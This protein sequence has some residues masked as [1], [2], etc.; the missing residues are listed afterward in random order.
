MGDHAAVLDDAHWLPHR[1]DPARGTVEFIR[2]ARERL[3]APAFL[4][5]A[6]AASPQDICAIP[7]AEVAAHHPPQAPQHFIFHTAFCRSTLLVRA[8]EQPGLCAGLSE[9]GVIASLV[10]AGP[11][12]Q[13]AIAPVARLLARP[14]GAGENGAE[15]VF[16][17]P[18]NHANMIAGALLEARPEARAALMTN[19]LPSFLRAVVRKGMLG[20]RWARTLYLEMMGYAGMDLGMDGREQFAMTDLQAGALAWFLNQRFLIALEQRFGA[21]VRVLDGDAFGADPAGTLAAV[22]RFTGVP[23][24]TG[25]PGRTS[26]RVTVTVHSVGP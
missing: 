18:T 14:W 15:P 5:D 25:S 12:A 26:A 24:D 17:K 20:R 8:L 1:F 7:L 6:V 13:G 22:G 21:R 16:V 23:I 9:P 4:A 10:N 19:P 3:A 2:L 11:A